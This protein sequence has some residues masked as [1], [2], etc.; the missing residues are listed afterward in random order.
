MYNVGT[1]ILVLAIDNLWTIISFI[2]M[3]LQCNLRIKD[4]LGTELL[5]SGGGGSSNYY[6]YYV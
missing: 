3:L 5:S 4:S 2:S 6:M 1:L